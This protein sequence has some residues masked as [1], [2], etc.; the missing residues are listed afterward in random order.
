MARRAPK[1]W[2]QIAFDSWALSAEAWLVVGLRAARLAEGGPAGCNE[3]RLMITEKIDSGL[4]LG[5]AL[6]TGQLGTNP[7]Q[8]LGSSVSY[9]LAG[10]RAN[11]KR[12]SRR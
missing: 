6:V 1:S 5:T 2:P 10:V 4:E 3:A 9:Y 7:K 12:L 11:R 8:I